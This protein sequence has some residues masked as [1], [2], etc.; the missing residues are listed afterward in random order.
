M[1]WRNREIVRFDEYP[2]RL[3]GKLFLTKRGVFAGVTILWFLGFMLPLVFFPVRFHFVYANV[4]LD[5]YFRLE[6]V[7]F[8][9]IRWQKEVPV[10]RPRLERLGLIAHHKEQDAIS[11]GKVGGDTARWNI[12][13][14]FRGL[15]SLRHRL[16]D[17]GLG[18][19]LASFFIPDRYLEYIRVINE[20]ENRGRFTRFQWQTAVGSKNP[21][22]AAWLVGGLWAIK[23]EILGLLQTRYRFQGRPGISVQPAFGRDVL[24]TKV[25]CI[26]QV[27]LGQIILAGLKE[28]TRRL[29]S[30]G[31][32]EKA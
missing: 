13:D 24:D 5:D 31:R 2:A 22:Y 26:F 6:M 16:K 8:P 28:Y 10:V 4:G 30:S 17:Y 29:L 11:Q 14:I 18:V 32:G 20:L 12:P 23:G 3:K 21:A 9:F 19:T 27:K 7:I 25:D 15:N 1:T